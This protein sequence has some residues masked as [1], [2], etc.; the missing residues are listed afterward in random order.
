MDFQEFEQSVQ[1][2][3][4]RLDDFDRVVA[5]QRACFPAMSTWTK[6]QFFMAMILILSVLGTLIIGL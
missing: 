5:L 2:R 6:A 3:T 1:L 4:L